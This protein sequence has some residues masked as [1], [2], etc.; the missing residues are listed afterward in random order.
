MDNT[1]EKA[2]KP[3]S[4]ISIV[5]HQ[6][7]IAADKRGLAFPP[8]YNVGN[9]LASAK[10]AL[11]E[12]ENRD[13]KRI[14][15]ANG[16][17]TNVVTEES[18]V[19]TLFDMCVQGL[20][21]AKKQCYFIVYGNKLTL[22]RSYF[23]D[24][25]VAE[26][27]MPGLSIYCDVIYKGE[28]FKPAKV[29]TKRGFIT[30]VNEHQIAWPRTSK[31]IVGAYCGGTYTNPETGEVEELGIEL[32]DMDQIRTS[33]KKSKTMNNESFHA[34]QPDLACKRTV[35]RRFTKQYIT[36]AIDPVLAE[37]LAR[38]TDEAIEAEVSEEISTQANTQVMQLP[39]PAAAPKAKR[40]PAT[41]PAPVTE[42]EPE[43]TPEPDPVPDEFDEFA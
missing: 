30:L 26:R 9:A 29:R 22:Q 5:H 27:A 41:E 37:S 24:Q 3:T 10:I 2:A 32:M 42:P 43:P 14:I 1:L 35:I 11:A 40:Q 28:V 17:S 18:I 20:N 13:R 8:D 38:T 36:T 19:N 15:D 6:I 16:K 31:E 23:G 4:V 25:V 21:V 12:V 7:S 39:E 33:W 34:Q